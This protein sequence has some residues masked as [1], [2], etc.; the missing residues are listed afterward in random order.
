M[1]S[2]YPAQFEREMGCTEAEWLM[3]LPQALGPHAFE[4]SGQSVLV[5]IGAGK[6]TLGWQQGTP[7]RIGRVSIP[8]L[9]V[10][11]RF[12]GLDDTQRY[13]FMQHFD[14]YMQ[15]GGG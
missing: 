15:R 6:L 7:R 2:F 10:D 8:R 11:F 13:T 3:Y 1:Q 4:F 14:L 5:H 12:D 9:Q